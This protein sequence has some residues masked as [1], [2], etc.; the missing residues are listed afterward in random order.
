MAFLNQYMVAVILLL[1]EDIRLIYYR[2]PLLI[3]LFINI[4]VIELTSAIKNPL[5]EN[6]I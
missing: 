4:L 2:N 1:R 6:P 5:H 3:N